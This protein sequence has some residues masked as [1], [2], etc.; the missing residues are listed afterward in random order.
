M[1]ISKI[2]EILM[3]AILLKCPCHFHTTHEDMGLLIKIFFPTPKKA[4]M[5]SKSE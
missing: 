5:T 2:A 4:D 3:K 1:K